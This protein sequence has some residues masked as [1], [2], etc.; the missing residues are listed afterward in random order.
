M[1]GGDAGKGGGAPPPPTAAKGAGAI[2]LFLPDSFLESRPHSSPLS[3][4]AQADGPLS[5]KSRM[6]ICSHPI[7]EAI[8]HDQ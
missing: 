8:C 6:R 7:V 4:K 1:E 3:V 5:K 2:Q